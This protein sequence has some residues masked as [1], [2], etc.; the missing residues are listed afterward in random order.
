VF[1]LGKIRLIC[2]VISGPGFCLCA[3]DQ[4]RTFFIPLKNDFSSQNISTQPLAGRR[5]VT[6]GCLE[7]L[8][9]LENHMSQQLIDTAGKS[10]D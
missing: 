4:P 6:R 1:R 2:K 9:A 3:E 8:A 5:G 10:N 7:R